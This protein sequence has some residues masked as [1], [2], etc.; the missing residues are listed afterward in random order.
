MQADWP[1]QWQAI[2]AANNAHAPM[3]LRVNTRRISVADYLKKLE[4]AGMAASLRV[5]RVWLLQQASAVQQMPGFGEDWSRCRTAR[6]N[7]PRRCC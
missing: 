2:L 5:W 4:A 1:V 3:T 6:R 7:W